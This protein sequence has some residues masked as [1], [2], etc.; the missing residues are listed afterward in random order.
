MKDAAR[1]IALMTQNIRDGYMPAE[2]QAVI[3][4]YI[5]QI[6]DKKYGTLRLQDVRGLLLHRP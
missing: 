3:D 4:A 2:S 1:D 5:K 6:E